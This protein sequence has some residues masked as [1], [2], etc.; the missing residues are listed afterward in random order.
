MSSKHLITKATLERML[1]AAS[2]EKRAQIVG[3]A[4]LALFRRQT[5]A[6]KQMNNA[7]VTNMRG[8]THSD[9][10][11][12][13][14]TAKFFIRHGTLHDWQV[15]QWLKPNSRGVARIVKYW[16]Q[17]DEEAKIKASNAA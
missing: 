17:L 2:P 1:Q 15:E 3:R 9:A 10:R 13:S 16:R 4:C 7:A 14:I 6:E 8:F 12:G 11:Q 5:E